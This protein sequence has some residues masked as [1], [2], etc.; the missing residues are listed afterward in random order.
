MEEKKIEE[1]QSKFE[2]MLNYLHIL[3]FGIRI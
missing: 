2:R 1:R 3:E